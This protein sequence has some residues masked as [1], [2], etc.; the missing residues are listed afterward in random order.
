MKKIFFTL[1]VSLIVEVSFAQS[2]YVD[3][4]NGNDNNSGTSLGQAWQ[5]LQFAFD[6]ATQGSTVYIKGGTYFENVYPSVSGTAGNPITFR[7]YQNDTVILDGTGTLQ[8]DMIYMEDEG[9]LTIENITIQNK[10]AAYATGIVISATPTGGATGITLK[11]I[12]VINISWTSNPN[13]TPTSNDNSNPIL[14]YG[15]GANQANAIKNILIDSCDIYGNITGF[16]ENISLDGN[17]D[18]FVVSHNIVHDNKNIGID[19]A[20]NYATSSNPA[21]DQAR[22]GHCFQNICFNNVSDYAT[23]GGIYVDGGK[24]IIIER[25]TSYGNGWGIE[26]GCEQNGSASNIIVRDNVIYNNKEAG[27]AIGG[28]DI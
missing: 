14:V 21:M 7:N 20:G 25:N 15:S 26:I 24:D 1:L 8:T 16:S 2:F 10:V 22:N 3:G 11:N 13:A 4:V 19:M 27:L 17:V 5:T 28:Y 6:N 23:S 12:K 9:Y 18:S